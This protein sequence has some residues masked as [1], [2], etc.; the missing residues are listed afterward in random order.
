[1]V[2][3]LSVRNIFCSAAIT[4]LGL[5][6]SLTKFRIADKVK[7]K[8]AK[9]ARDLSTNEESK[10]SVVIIRAK[11]PEKGIPKVGGHPHAM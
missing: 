10:S 4:D 11:V 5:L 2:P 3:E 8:D 9:I 6:S 7:T 1:M